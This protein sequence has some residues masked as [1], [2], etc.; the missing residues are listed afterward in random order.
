MSDQPTQD[1]PIDQLLAV[2]RRLRDPEHGCPW[3]LKQDFRSIV[4]STLEECYEL[5][6]AIEQEDFHHVGEELGDVLLQVVFHCRIAQDDPDDPF[7]I[8][9]VAKLI[10]LPADHVMG[11]MVAIGKGTKD[12]W[13]K[14]GQLPLREL[15]FENSF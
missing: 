4:P 7:D 10:N 12:S 8:D 11:P 6:S 5:A 1:R 2:M 14:P 13:P 9:E 15:V 3:D